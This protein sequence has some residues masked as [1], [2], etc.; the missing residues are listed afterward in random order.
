M[1]GG[2][3]AVGATAAGAG[4]VVSVVLGLGEGVTPGG[5]GVGASWG[6]TLASGDELRAA[7][8]GG[9]CEGGMSTVCVRLRGGGGGGR[10]RSSWSSGAADVMT[11]DSSQVTSPVA[12]ATG[13]SSDVVSSAHGSK[14]GARGRRFCAA[15][16]TVEGG[17]AKERNALVA[18]MA[19]AGASLLEAGPGLD[20]A[21]AFV[22]GAAWPGAEGLSA[23]LAGT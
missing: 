21:G 8:M 7:G 1:T 9:R 10:L 16:A 14:I 22:G 4:D 18:G 2:T 12:P 15:A 17:P 11:D 3:P 5:C 19:L 6:S 20:A 13:R 23:T